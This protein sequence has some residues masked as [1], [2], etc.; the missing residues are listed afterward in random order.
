MNYLQDFIRDVAPYVVLAVFGYIGKEVRA[1]RQSIE[2]LNL[3][4]AVILEKVHGHEK[5]IS[6]LEQKEK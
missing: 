1:V 6:N 4:V 3:N 5:R 2:K